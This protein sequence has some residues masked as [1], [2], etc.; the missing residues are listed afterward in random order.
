MGLGAASGVGSSGLH[1]CVGVGRGVGSKGEGEARLSLKASA[2]VRNRRAVYE[3]T[4]PKP[5]PPNG[6]VATHR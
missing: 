3:L 6:R 2:F 4:P 5:T 1:A